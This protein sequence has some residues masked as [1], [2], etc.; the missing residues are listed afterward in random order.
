MITPVEY[1]QK[2]VQSGEIISDANQW[3]VV[4]KLQALYAEL[5]AEERC[6]HRFSRFKIGCFPS[7]L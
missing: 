6:S 4:A 1:Y 7:Q 5:M 2:A 3:L